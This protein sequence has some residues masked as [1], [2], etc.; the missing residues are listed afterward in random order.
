MSDR[1]WARLEIGGGPV[2]YT[3]LREAIVTDGEVCI[4]P[5]DRLPETYA[6]LVALRLQGTSSD[7]LE[8]VWYSGEHIILEDWEVAGAHWEDLESWLIKNHVSFNRRSGGYPGVWEPCVAY[9][10]PTTGFTERVTTEQGTELV[11]L[12]DIR[13]HLL[14]GDLATWLDTNYAEIGPLP[15]LLLHK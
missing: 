5:H 6:E 10:R 9:F 3:A 8:G 2:S 14:D 4:G 1:A 7:L 12:C 11:P 13:Q 15:R